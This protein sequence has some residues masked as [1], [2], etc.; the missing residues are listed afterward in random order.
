M[1]SKLT[2]I[3][4]VLTFIAMRD[5]YLSICF[6]N[7]QMHLKSKQTVYKLDHNVEMKRFA[8]VRPNEDVV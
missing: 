4:I 3:L 1:R 6:S 7:P 5:F 8:V 2:A